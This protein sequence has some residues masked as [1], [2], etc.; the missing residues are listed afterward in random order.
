MQNK[1]TVVVVVPTAINCLACQSSTSGEPNP[2]W[3]WKDGE[4]SLKFLLLIPASL[5]L[6]TEWIGEISCPFLQVITINKHFLEVE[7]MRYFHLHYHLQ[8]AAHC[9][10]SYVVAFVQQTVCNNLIQ[11]EHFVCTLPFIYALPFKLYRTSWILTQCWS[12]SR[13][14][15]SNANGSNFQ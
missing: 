2:D 7:E 15:C 5:L 4:F 9:N 14:V 13:T 1:V 10:K 3:G 11:I 8:I 6:T 12:R